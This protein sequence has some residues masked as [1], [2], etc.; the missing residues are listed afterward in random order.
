V[1]ELSAVDGQ[2]NGWGRGAGPSAYPSSANLASSALS[3]G[4]EGGLGRKTGL[5]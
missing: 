1:L 5:F 3:P 2:E 4:N